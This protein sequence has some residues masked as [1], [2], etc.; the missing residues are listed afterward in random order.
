MA[1]IFC[2]QLLDDFVLCI[3]LTSAGKKHKYMYT[4]LV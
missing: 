4:I 2:A 3:C 1:D